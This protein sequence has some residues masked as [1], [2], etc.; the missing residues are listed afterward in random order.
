[1]YRSHR[2]I[3]IFSLDGC[4]NH[5]QLRDD[6]GISAQIAI[7]CAAETEDANSIKRV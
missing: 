7:R 6:I 4:S 3:I 1:M 2:R 5:S